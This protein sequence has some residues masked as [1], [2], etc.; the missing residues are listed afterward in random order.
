MIERPRGTRDFGMEEMRKRRIV[1]KK[2][3]SVFK[4]SGYREVSTPIIESLDLFL[5][6]SGKEIIKETY[7]FEDKGG[8]K[9]ALRP[10]LTA[11]VIRYYVNDLQMEAKPLK[12]FY[13]GN[14]FRY[15]RPQ[16][17]RYREFWQMGCEL[18]GTDNPEALAELIALAYHAIKEAG[19]VDINL[20]I[21][22]LDYLGKQVEETLQLK[23]PP[24][25]EFH[26]G[27][28]AWKRDMFRLID[29]EDYEGV[30]DQFEE[31]GIAQEKIDGF[32]NFLDSGSTGDLKE[33]IEPSELK[34]YE[35]I[36]GL[37]KKFGITKVKPG[38]KI[39]RGLDYY[40][41]IVFEIDAPCL[42][43]E[44]QLCGGGSYELI[45]LFG[46]KEIPTSGFAI[47]FDRV[48]MALEEEG[49][50]FEFSPSVEVY[51]MSVNDDMI[52][53]ATKIASKLRES[54]MKVD[55]DLMRRKMKKAFEYANKIGA[56][57]V[58]IVGPDEFERK[59]VIVKD[60]ES[61]NEE[62]VKI[63]KIDGW[64]EKNL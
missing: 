31:V 37:L 43:A 56:K 53:I 24:L 16:K 41:G 63:D 61:G 51:I 20:R 10:E 27:G 49:Y 50:D 11:P 64:M 54:G 46:G 2:M 25:S 26:P 3:R 58:V 13:F 18:I 17:G 22:Q 45:G 48:M 14:C 60:M 40:K 1:E 9:I 19:L 6:K 44:K 5:K 52:G 15:D 21:G 12:L 62:E 23:S 34:P 38:M 30:R 7:S 55:M 28:A 57:K 32:M 59:V 39:A 4:R 36:I 8:R 33:F 35:E 47:G 42:G 29:K